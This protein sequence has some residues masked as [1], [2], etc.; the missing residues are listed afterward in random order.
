ME[1]IPHSALEEMIAAMSPQ[2]AFTAR[3]HCL[4][5]NN[6]YM[7]FIKESGVIFSSNCFLILLFPLGR[8]Q[9]VLIWDCMTSL[10][11]PRAHTAQPTPA[12]LPKFAISLFS[13]CSL[14]WAGNLTWL[15]RDRTWGNGCK[16]KEGRFRW[17]IRKKFFFL[18]VVRPWHELH[19]KA[20][21]APSL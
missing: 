21:A 12:F 20:V 8:L 18:R 3:C 13:R 7:T 6:F 5:W 10:P 11:F 19:R 4:N 15:G 16:L 17:G 9:V 2:L 1:I 14:C